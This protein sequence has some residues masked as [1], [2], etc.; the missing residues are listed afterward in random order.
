[1]WHGLGPKFGWGA[2]ARPVDRRAA[3]AMALSA[4]M[5]ALIALVVGR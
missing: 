5:A 2:N 1:M 3:S 4:L